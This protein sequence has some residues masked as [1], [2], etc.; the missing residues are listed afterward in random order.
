[1]HI[2]IKE[3][4]YQNK[5]FISED[6]TEYMIPAG[7]EFMSKDEIQHQIDIASDFIENFIKENNYGEVIKS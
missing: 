4:D 3:I 1:M 6:G 7:C 2:L 5:T